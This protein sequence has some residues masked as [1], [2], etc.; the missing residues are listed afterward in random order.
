MAYGSWVRFPPWP[1]FKNQWNVVAVTR[2]LPPERPKVKVTPRC[3]LGRSREKYLLLKATKI[4]R[5][6]SVLGNGF[7]QRSFRHQALT[8]EQ[9]FSSLGGWGAIWRIFD[10]TTVE[11]IS[12]IH[13]T[14]KF[15]A[16]NLRKHF[17]TKPL[18][19][20]MR[21]PEKKSI[22]AQIFQVYSGWDVNQTYS[23]DFLIHPLSEENTDNSIRN[24]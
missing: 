8:L 21:R 23:F 13:R 5:K 22:L 11:R 14:G 12:M 4:A 24:S 19:I 16:A 15:S 10:L 1:G 6:T 20:A 7:L 9:F 18:I 17:P 2:W 3:W